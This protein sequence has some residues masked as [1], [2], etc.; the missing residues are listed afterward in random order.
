MTGNKTKFR[1]LVVDDS[2]LM[3]TTIRKILEH[4]KRIGQIDEAEN[5]Q[6]A[7]DLVKKH[8]FH[9]I[10]LDI[11]M[12]VMDGMEFLKRSKI[13]TDA[14]IIIVSSVVNNNPTTREKALYFGA[15]DIVAKPTGTISKG[16]EESKSQEILDI[17][18]RAIAEFDSSNS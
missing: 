6:V 13:H 12:P 8:E 2:F 17:I 4:E 3:R 16:L 9:I 15:Y 18:A 11:E 14:C 10:M 7:L 1:S 5:G